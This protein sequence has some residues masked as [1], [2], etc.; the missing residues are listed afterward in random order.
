MTKCRS[1]VNMSWDAHAVT[2]KQR[3]EEKR[4]RRSEDKQP[5][6]NRPAPQEGDINQVVCLRVHLGPA[7]CVCV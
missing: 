7:V 3:G 5:A 4:G 1:C 2:Q 6:R